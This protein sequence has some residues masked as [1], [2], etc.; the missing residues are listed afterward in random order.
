MRATAKPQP[1]AW[2]V[3][4]LRPVGQHG[5]VRR[6]AAQ[7]GLACIALST[8]RIA[9]QDDARTQAALGKALAAP[10]VVFTSP[11]AVRCAS[12][13][14]SLRGARGRRVFA[15]GA[16]TAAALRRAGIAGV[17]VPPR[18]DSDA[19]LALDALQDVGGR[20]V[21]LVTAPGG[22]DRIAPGLR[23][24]G[25]EVVR[26]D[27]Y[28]R[29]AQAP[30]PRAWNALRAVRGKLAIALSSGD[31]LDTLMAH[32]PGDLRGRLLG[33]RILAGSERLADIAQ[34]HGFDDIRVAEGA[35]PAELLA[36]VRDGRPRRAI[37]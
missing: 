5:S 15:I 1:P 24:R 8:M 10:F 21:G 13:L 33:A 20:R 17:Q 35:R 9:P 26:A 2:Y 6:A 37:R 22:R 7:A 11:N 4:S 30:M 25:A 14:A 29:E 32:V 12:A 27:V 23:A 28:A 19:L 36:V 3:I 18:A 31:A 16:G 34:R